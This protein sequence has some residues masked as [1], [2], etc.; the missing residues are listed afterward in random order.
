MRNKYIYLVSVVVFILTTSILLRKYHNHN[1]SKPIN[2]NIQS[3]NDNQTLDLSEICPQIILPENYKYQEPIN[4]FFGITIK[5][6]IGKICS[7]ILGPNYKQ[8][9][10]GF[11]GEQIQI[12]AYP[13]IRVTAKK[14]LEV[15]SQQI[16][17]K[18]NFDKYI[19][20]EKS[21]Y[22]GKDQIIVFENDTTTYQIIWRETLANQNID[23]VILEIVNQIITQ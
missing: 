15:E 11:S 6:N 17:N 18:E 22:G 13:K 1:N 12:N 10:E 19:Q 9:Y 7:V 23:N 8:G 21:S 2:Q 4:S 5:G 20:Y 14:I 3:D 16:L